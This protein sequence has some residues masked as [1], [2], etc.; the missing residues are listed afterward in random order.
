MSEMS[1]ANKV[2]PELNY[3]VAIQ[4]MFCEVD[5]KWKQITKLC[6]LWWKEMSTNLLA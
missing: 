1:N 5:G 3:E 4:L 6:S 2:R